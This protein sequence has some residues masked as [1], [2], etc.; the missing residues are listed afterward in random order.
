MKRRLIIVGV[1]LVMLVMVNTVVAKGPPRE[2]VITG[3]GIEGELVVRDTARLEH[4]GI[5]G[6]MVIPESI[7]MPSHTGP[8]YTLVRDGWDKARYYP[9]LSGGPGYVYY[10]G[11][12]NGWS[13]YDGH[14]FAATPEGDAEMRSLL[15]T[16]GIRFDA[17]GYYV[18]TPSQVR[19]F[20]PFQIYRP[21]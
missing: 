4:L 14:W 12:I 11:L 20:S 10:V 8:G 2:V 13:E 18:S 16:Q 17:A 15:A 1:M 19:P 9:D 6:L 3:P 5:V 7:G 21:L